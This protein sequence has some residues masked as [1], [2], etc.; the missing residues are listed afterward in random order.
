EADVPVNGGLSVRT[1]L[2]P[3]LQK[4]G[5]RVLIDGLVAFD[6]ERGWRGAANNGKRIETTGD[7]GAVLNEIEI[8][9]D[10]APWR[11]AVV[12]QVDR[13]KATVGLRPPR[14]ADGSLA[15]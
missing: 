4:I 15:A 12:L 1:T 3:K 9:T 13:A 11:L 5:R 6:R 10:L 2:D 7:W 8:P 14:E